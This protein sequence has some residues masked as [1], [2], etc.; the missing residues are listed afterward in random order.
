MKYLRL[1]RPR[2]LCIAG[3]AIIVGANACSSQASQRLPAAT[4]KA[5]LLQGGMLVHPAI[6]PWKSDILLRRGP[7]GFV[8]ARVDTALR[9]DDVQRV[10]LSGLYIHSANAFSA[11]PATRVGEIAMYVI[12]DGPSPG[13]A[14]V[15]LLTSRTWRSVDPAEN[16]PA[17]PK[18]ERVGC[19]T[20]ERGDW[21]SPRDADGIGGSLVPASMRLHRQY[22]HHVGREHVLAATDLNGKLP[23]GR[24][25]Y[26]GWFALPGD[27]LRVTF[28]S[29]FV[30]AMFSLG[31][32]GNGY[33]GTV[34][35]ANDT[36]PGLR[37]RASVR[38]QR[39]ICPDR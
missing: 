5:V 21:D 18:D 2:R 37:S 23:D 28:S 16:Y 11:R 25:A 6:T 4:S 14:A 17:G 33:S 12:R 27:S 32:E 26:Y 9:V 35:L 3:L 34:R 22:L 1:D 10:D 20:V 30:V 38:L 39:V 31:R 7:H 15:M 8:V 36:E 13:D 24:I 19:Y 29:G